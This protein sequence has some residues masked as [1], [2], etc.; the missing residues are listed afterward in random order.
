MY[1]EKALF[2][3]LYEITSYLTNIYSKGFSPRNYLWVS[4]WR[5]VRLIPAL[6]DLQKRKSPCTLRLVAIGN[7]EPALASTAYKTKVSTAVVS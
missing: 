6:L 5:I 7:R 1:V 2:G 4:Y 3:F